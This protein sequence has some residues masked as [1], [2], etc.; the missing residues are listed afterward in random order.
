MTNRPSKSGPR[1]RRA[2]RLFVSAPVTAARTRVAGPG[3]RQLTRTSM[4][5]SRTRVAGPGPRWLVRTRMTALVLALACG[6]GLATPAG[7]TDEATATP[8]TS[9]DRGPRTGG[10][11]R[12]AHPDSPAIRSRP[13]R[14]T[15]GSSSGSTPPI[16]PKARWCSSGSSA[17]PWSRRRCGARRSG[18]TGTP[19]RADGRSTTRRSPNGGRGRSPNFCGRTSTSPMRGSGRV[20]GYG[21]E[22]L[23]DD[24]PPDAP[25]QRRVEIVSFHEIASDGAA[26]GVVTD[27][28][29]TPADRPEAV[30]GESAGDG[31]VVRVPRAGGASAGAREEDEAEDAGESGYIAIQ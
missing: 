3:S 31:V 25:A 26:G 5:A 16:S 22:R 14:S 6:G 13:A 12:Q 2:P 8:G 29:G 1:V 23:R 18:C 24:L 27:A 17:R 9:E 15:C 21:E 11:H 20:R 19:T 28:P 4:T 7:A 30:A 10:D